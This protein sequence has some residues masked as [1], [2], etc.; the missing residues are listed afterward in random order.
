MIR[1][2]G[3]V[4]V[5]RP[6]PD[7]AGRE[8]REAGA[9]GEQPVEVGDGHELGIRLAVHVDELGEH[10]LDAALVELAA[11]LVGGRGRL[12]GHGDA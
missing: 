7:V 2:R 8:A 10:E 4:R 12:D 9:V 11:E 6:L 5:V 1:H 3:D